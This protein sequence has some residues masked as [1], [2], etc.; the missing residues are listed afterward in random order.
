MGNNARLAAR[1]S[2][3]VYIRDPARYDDIPPLDRTAEAVSDGVRER[4]SAL[5][6]ISMMQITST[7]GEMLGRNIGLP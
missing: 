7:L 2:P 6:A 3:S 5:A 1:I 4:L